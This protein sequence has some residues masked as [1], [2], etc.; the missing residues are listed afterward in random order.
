ME[1]DME[2]VK[3]ILFELEKLKDFR[4][5]LKIPDEDSVKVAYHLKI[6]EQGELIEQKV[7]YA[8]NKPMWMYASLTWQGHEF[9]DSVRNDSVWKKLIAKLK[10]EGGGIPFEV[11]KKL[12]L[13]YAEQK[14]L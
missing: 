14:I 7:H 11:L 3:K 10:E 8:D 2:L 1:R 9:L 5:E 13:K 6:M 4:E 12:A